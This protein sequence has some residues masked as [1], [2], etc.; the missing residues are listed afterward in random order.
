MNITPSDID[1]TPR[2]EAKAE[3]IMFFIV[4]SMFFMSSGVTAEH[5]QSTSRPAG[6]AGAK[7]WRSFVSRVRPK[8]SITSESTD[9]L[10]RHIWQWKPAVEPAKQRDLSA[11][12]NRGHH[13]FASDVIFWYFGYFLIWSMGVLYYIHL[14]AL[15][16]E[17]K[18]AAKEFLNSLISPQN[19]RNFPAFPCFPC[20]ICCKT[21]ACRDVAVSFHI[22]LGYGTETRMQYVFEIG[23]RHTHLFNMCGK[24][25]MFWFGAPRCKESRKANWCTLL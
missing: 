6:K 14:I 11:I 12:C 13:R 1:H 10:L 21:G 5:G 3:S 24:D 2:V 23:L 17:T 15:A 19:S 7:S 18:V 9:T 25:T 8:T 22:R 4:F 20:L 16:A